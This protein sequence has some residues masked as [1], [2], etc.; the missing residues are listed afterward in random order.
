MTFGDSLTE[1]VISLSPTI[2]ALDLPGSYPSVLRNLLRARYPTQSL[3]M[4]NAGN[5]GEFAS[6]E[7]VR[8]FRST[9]IAHQPEVV[10]L[11]EGTNDLLFQQ[12]GVEP[13]LQALEIDDERR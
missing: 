13:A 11:M 10:L 1:G 9:L 12:R 7:G 8:R 5:A 3:T 6:G 2:L 4:F